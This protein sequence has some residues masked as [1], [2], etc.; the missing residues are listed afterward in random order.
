M[1][2]LLSVILVLAAYSQAS[3]KFAGGGQLGSGATGMPYIG[4]NYTIAFWMRAATAGQ[5]STTH[6][7]TF[8]CRDNSGGSQTQIWIESSFASPYGRIQ[9][10]CGGGQPIISAT[11]ITDASW[12][13]VALV[14]SAANSWKIYIDGSLD[15]TSSTSCTPNSTAN[16]IRYA[17]HQ[18]GNFAFSGDMAE[19]AFWSVAL[20]AA[21][22]KALAKGVTPGN[23]RFEKLLLY[24]PLNARHTT[25]AVAETEID[26]SGHQAANGVMQVNTSTGN[27]FTD[28]HCPCNV[29]AGSETH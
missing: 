14:Q 3:L 19:V 4:T 18:S 17:K 6:E 29:T 20:T 25:G 28:D 15:N 23:I 13:H 5:F 2:R 11:A 27:V 22:I 8:I 10:N 9:A 26:L 1:K 7:Q 24:A 16:G 21:E 12:H